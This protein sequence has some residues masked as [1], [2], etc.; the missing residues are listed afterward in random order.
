MGTNAVSA[1]LMESGLKKNLV[2]GHVHMPLPPDNATAGSLEN[3]W[4]SFFQTLSRRF[5]ISGSS[6]VLSVPA[7]RFLFRNLS[8][9]FSD[10]KKIQQVLP[11]ELE[12]TLPGPVESFLFDF[13]KLPFTTS[14]GDTPLIAAGV[15]TRWLSETLDSLGRAG[16]SPGIIVPSGYPLAAWL[17][18]RKADGRQRLVIDYDGADCTVLLTTGDTVGL[19]RGFPL[20]AGD[21][22]LAGVLQK[23]ILRTLGGFEA[24]FETRLSVTETVMH[25]LSPALL[26]PMASSI[27]HLPT[28]MPD[29]LTDAGW[30]RADTAGDDWQPAHYDTALGCVSLGIEGF[31]GLNFRKGP[32]AAKSRLAAYRQWLPRLTVHAAV[33]A[34]LWLGA[35]AAES[36][37]LKRKVTELDRRITGVF[38]STFPDVRTI[39]DPVHQMRTGLQELK[40]TALGPAGAPPALRT[41][42]ML[43]EISARI[44][45]AVDVHLT[46]LVAGEDGILISGTT[47]SF[48]IVD[49]I[50]N[51][52]E[53]FE[54]FLSVKITSADMDRND[55]RIRFK[56]KIQPRMEEDA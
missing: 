31:S 34:A 47:A 40:N 9:P 37:A 19:I 16:I 44:P 27:G 35:M 54:G 41:I 39:V 53:A 17:C 2:V 49:D 23:E 13:Q 21:P 26:A 46:K 18:T 12:A 28:A 24:L 55:N 32:L 48:N 51:N 14:T 3:R 45:P 6:C 52:L 42:D 30:D 10:G 38:Q 20:S 4:D 43:R 1:V 7:S 33:V 29:L 11:F 50:K 36:Y 56:L 25:G 22:D 15:E 8:V 5:D